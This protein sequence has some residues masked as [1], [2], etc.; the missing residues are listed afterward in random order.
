MMIESYRQFV[1]DPQAREQFAAA[2]RL[3]AAPG[4]IPA[5][6]CCTAGKDAPAGCPPSSSPHSASTRGLSSPTT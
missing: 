5:M 1:P 3:I 4:G 6:F 2:A